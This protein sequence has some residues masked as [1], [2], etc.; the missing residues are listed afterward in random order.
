MDFRIAGTRGEALEILSELGGDG[1]LVAGGT[2]VMVQIQRR[3]LAPPALVDISRIEELRRVSHNGRTGI[4]A[5]VTHAS[6]ARDTGILGRMPALAEACRTVGGWQTQEAGTIAGNVCNASPAADTIPPLLVADTVVHLDSADGGRSLPLRDFVL[7]RRRVDRRSDEMVVELESEPIGLRTGEVYLKVGP[8]GG[9]EVALVGLA[10]RVELEADLETVAEARIAACAVA[11]RPFRAGGAERL[12]TG[13]TAGAD[14][15]RDAGALL[16]QEAA[17]IDDQRATAAYRRR[18]LAPL[19][20]RAVTT[21][22]DRAKG[23]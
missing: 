18:V 13:S 4:G 11:E 7:G 10:V 9:M 3:E 17:P 5:L 21:A 12:L 23:A 2:D 14:V 20:A 6:A 16:E 8:R 1:R 19:L 22:V 15:L